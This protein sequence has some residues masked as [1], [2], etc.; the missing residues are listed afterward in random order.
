VLVAGVEWLSDSS[1]AVVV[2]AATRVEKS[3]IAL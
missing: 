2:G 3:A 1:L